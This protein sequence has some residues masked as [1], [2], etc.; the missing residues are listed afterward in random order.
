M[1]KK[2]RP[3]HKRQ[4]IVGLAKP[5]SSRSRQIISGHKLRP[6]GKAVVDRD[7]HIANNAKDVDFRAD[8]HLA[9]NGRHKQNLELLNY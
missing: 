8:Q 9:S 6:D 4:A 1:V 7:G 3:M 5:R 2:T